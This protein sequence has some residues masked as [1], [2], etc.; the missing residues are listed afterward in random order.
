MAKRRLTRQQAWRIEKVQQER[1]QRAQR[2]AVDLG[3]L[4]QEQLGQA[5]SGLVVANFGASVEVEDEAGGEPHRCRLRQNLELAVV[6][7]KVVWQPVGQQGDGVVI[8]VEPRRSL[9]ARPDGRGQLKSLAANIDQIVVV[10]APLPAYSTDL[11]D[12]YVVAAEHIGIAPLLL[13]NKIDLLSGPE[14]R[15]AV[16]AVIGNYRRLGYQVIHASTL[17][18][19]GLDEIIAALQHHTSVFVGQSGVGKSSLVRALLPEVAVKV[20]SLMEGSGLG[21]HT[22]SAARYYRLPGGGAIIDSPG[23]RDFALWHMA[24]E[25]LAYGF[26]EFR[27]FLGGCRFRDCSHRDEPG[28]ALQAAIARGEISKERLASFQRLVDAQREMH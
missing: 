18:R 12:Q 5:Q 21:R 1:L 11:I 23:V 14:Q 15:A 22:T 20:G 25:Q 26:V 24:S 17:A 2:Q 16:E 9:L 7:D 10:A 19:H 4:D 8:A 13:F 27:P 6:G 3:G 28:C